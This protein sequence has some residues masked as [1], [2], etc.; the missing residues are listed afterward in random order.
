MMFDRYVADQSRSLTG[1]GLLILG[2]LV[3]HGIAL[4][5]LVIYSFVHVEEVAPPP[6][7]VVFVSSAAPPP[8]PPPPPPPAGKKSP[9]PKT[10]K[11]PILQP[12]EVQPLTQPKEVDKPPEEEEAD[13]DDGEAAGVEG[14]VKGGVAGG[15]VGGT[16]G[17]TVGGVIGGVVSSAP[18]PPP[19]AP[20]KVPPHVFEQ[21]ILSKVIPHL[22]DV[23]KIQRR[24]TGPATYRALVCID[25]AGSVTRVQ[26]IESIPGGD[27]VCTAALH[28]WKFKPQPLPICSIVELEFQIE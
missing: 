15:V 11:T 26:T 28:Q 22:P 13:E 8:P 18:P 4:V 12:K 17:G 9:T 27:E 24:G 21:A 1:R 23:V 3:L 14:G 20:K 7:T 10:P 25:A 6:L 19:V 5:A 2:S 16:V